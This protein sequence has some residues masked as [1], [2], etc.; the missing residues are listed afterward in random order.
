MAAG[1][2]RIGLRDCELAEWRSVRE[3]GLREKLRHQRDR[4]SNGSRS[5]ILAVSRAL[6]RPAER[7]CRRPRPAR[8]NRAV[9]SDSILCPGFDTAVLVF[10]SGCRA[11]RG[12]PDRAFRRQS[13]TGV[14]LR[15]WPRARQTG[16]G[17]RHPAVLRVSE[18]LR[19]GPRLRGSY[20]R[21]SRLR[22]IRTSPA[23]AR[24]RE[25]C[26]GSRRIPEN[27]VAADRPACALRSR[28][29]LSLRRRGSGRERCA[30][31]FRR[32]QP[33]RF[34][35]RPPVLAAGTPI[36]TGRRWHLRGPGSPAR[37]S[38]GWC[39]TPTPK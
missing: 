13:R 5:G 34:S 33:T 18:T 17:L 23:T 35:A 24:K 2:G 6:A 3:A 38:A 20:L 14:V 7:F 31:R 11:W 29:R 21:E 8:S 15:R 9:I 25:W 1:F 26:R 36:E 16:R 30:A 27:R 10:Q 37:T 39:C 28:T 22:D 32:R 19:R 12:N 4:T